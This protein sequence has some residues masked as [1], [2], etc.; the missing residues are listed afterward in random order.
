MNEWNLDPVLVERQMGGESS[1]Q[2]H[3]SH[4]WDGVLSREFPNPKVILINK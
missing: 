3:H 1:F 4:G 2:Q